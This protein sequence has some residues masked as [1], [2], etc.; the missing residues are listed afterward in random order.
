MENLCPEWLRIHSPQLC[1]RGIYYHRVYQCSGE[2][3]F[4]E[5]DKKGNCC[6]L[7]RKQ[8][9]YNEREKLGMKS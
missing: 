4:R 5:Y 1:C 3:K 6:I 2:Q 8:I 9:Y 7:K